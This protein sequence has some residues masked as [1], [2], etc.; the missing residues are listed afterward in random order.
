[1]DI[2]NLNELEKESIER[3]IPVIGK[4][5]GAW[6]LEMIKQYEPKKILE[7]GSANGY[8]GCILGS[9]GGEL[10][11]VEL[12]SKIA[13]E[14]MINFGKHNV[15]AKVLIGDGVKIVKDLANNN[16]QFDLIFIDFFKKGYM[17][18][19]EDCIK[20]TKPNAIIIADNIT[21]ED[22]QDFKEAVLNHPNLK[23]EIINIKDGLCHCVRQ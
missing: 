3:K 22:C 23:S 18:V 8:S 10:T 16:N 13:E 2:E 20:M 19:L 17:Q 9:E 6:L 15:N 5:K 7:L 11:T 4:D 21:M 14:A 12:D 1:M